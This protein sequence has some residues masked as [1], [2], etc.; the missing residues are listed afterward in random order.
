MFGYV[1][2][3]QTAKQINKEAKDIFKDITPN[4]DCWFWGDDRWASVRLGMGFMWY[5]RARALPHEPLW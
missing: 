2:W 4:D 5:S 3:S 1:H